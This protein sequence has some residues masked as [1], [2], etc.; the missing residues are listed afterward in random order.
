MRHH[1]GGFGLLVRSGFIFGNVIFEGSIVW[2][3]ENRYL[4]DLW[5]YV[6]IYALFFEGIFHLEF[7]RQCE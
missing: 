1:E 7:G 5:I 6:L 4:F 2:E 3:L